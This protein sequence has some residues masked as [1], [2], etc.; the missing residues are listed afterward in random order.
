MGFLEKGCEYMLNNGSREGLAFRGVRLYLNKRFINEIF[1][2]R[3][4]CHVQ[5]G[6]NFPTRK[7]WQGLIDGDM[8]QPLTVVNFFQS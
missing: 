3:V 1:N 5:E 7:Q 2:W 4:S 8:T 6:A